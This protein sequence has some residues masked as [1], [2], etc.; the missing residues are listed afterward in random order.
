MS[1]GHGWAVSHGRRIVPRPD[2]AV[3]TILAVPK[4]ARTPG[5]VPVVEGSPSEWL[6]TALWSRFVAAVHLDATSFRLGVRR[7]DDLIHEGLTARNDPREVVV[8][9]H[10]R[11]TSGLNSENGR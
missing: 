6:S 1:I 8:D 10:A 3:K 2:W 11:S 7:R 5:P 4:S 9:P